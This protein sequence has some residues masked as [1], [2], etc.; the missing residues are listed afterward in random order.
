LVPTQIVSKGEFYVKANGHRMAKWAQ[1]PGRW[2]KEKK[3]R[4]KSRFFPGIAG[5]M[6]SQW[7]SLVCQIPL[8]GDELV[9]SSGP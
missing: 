9:T 3:R 1:C 8:F 2:S 5:A 4:H 7:E 6:A